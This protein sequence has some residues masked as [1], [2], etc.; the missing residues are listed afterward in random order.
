MN[1]TLTLQRPASPFVGRNSHLACIFARVAV[2]GLS[3]RGFQDSDIVFVASRRPDREA[4]HEAC[5]KMNA[6][7]ILRG[8]LNSAPAR[9]RARR[10]GAELS[11]TILFRAE[12]CA[13]D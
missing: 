6:F 3:G 13:F 7:L 12:Q 1:V 9:N 4:C 8:H 10:R 11:R 2:L 5:D